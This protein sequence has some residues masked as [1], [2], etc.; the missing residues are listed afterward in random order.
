MKWTLSS[1]SEVIDSVLLRS[2]GVAVDPRKDGKPIVVRELLRRRL[3]LLRSRCWLV[4]SVRALWTRFLR[5][6]CYGV[7][8]RLLAQYGGHRREIEMEGRG[9]VRGK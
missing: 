7:F 1:I 8:A 2:T 5:V 3:D 4:P 9:G 6:W